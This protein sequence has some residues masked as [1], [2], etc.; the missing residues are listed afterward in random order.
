MSI[1]LIA[2]TADRENDVIDKISNII[3]DKRTVI[4][5]NHD[6]M[7]RSLHE[8]HIDTTTAVNCETIQYAREVLQACIN[9]KDEIDCI[10]VLLST[11]LNDS[12][13]NMSIEVYRL[14]KIASENAENVV[15]ATHAYYDVNNKIYTAHGL[16]SLLS[17]GPD[18][19]FYR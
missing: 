13:S 11:F 4:L 18:V 7:A 9:H 6:D 12:Q 17:D 19:D 8:M 5:E 2:Y 10:V 3:S 16:K 1:N 14:Y 15:I